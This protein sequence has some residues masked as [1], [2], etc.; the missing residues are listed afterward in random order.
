MTDLLIC[1]LQLDEAEEI[2]KYC[3][4]C[5]IESCRSFWKSYIQ[6]DK[7]NF[8]KYLVSKWKVSVCITQLLGHFTLY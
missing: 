6:Y 3:Q 7:L 1:A 4:D 2:L 8:N 5:A